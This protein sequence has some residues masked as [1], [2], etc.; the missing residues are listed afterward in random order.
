MAIAFTFSVNAQIETPQ[1]SPAS[2]LEQRVGLT[3]V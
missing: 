3:D 1:S 2:K